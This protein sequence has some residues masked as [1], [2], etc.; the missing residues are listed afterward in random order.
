DLYDLFEIGRGSLLFYVGDV[1]GKGPEA[2]ALGG[3]VRHTLR[4]GAIRERRPRRRLQLLNAVILNEDPSVRFCTIALGRLQ[5]RPHAARV[6]LACAGH[7]YP[8]LLR[9]DGTVETLQCRGLLIGVFPDFEL[10][11]R[12]LELGPGETL[13]LYTDGV[14]ER[15]HAG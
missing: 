1:C 6:T 12:R 9:A 11:E 3:L 7:P 5:L 2:A 13:L 14:S 4:A 8:L 10:S 15:R